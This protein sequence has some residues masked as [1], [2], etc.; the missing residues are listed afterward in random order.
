MRNLVPSLI[1]FA[2]GFVLAAFLFTSRPAGPTQFYRTHH[3]NGAVEMEV[4]LDATGLWHG[5]LRTYHPSGR[6]RS[7]TDV[8]HGAMG[9]GTS[10]EDSEPDLP[11]DAPEARSP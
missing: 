3:P 4:P 11:G 6:L 7:V 1:G 9:R 5:E 10:Y 8:N 2:A